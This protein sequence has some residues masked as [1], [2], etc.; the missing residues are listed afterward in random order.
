M[1]S[2]RHLLPTHRH[3]VDYIEFALEAEVH[4]SN[5]VLRA[6]EEKYRSAGTPYSFWA[7]TEGA[8]LADF[9]KRTFYRT[10]YVDTPDNSLCT[11]FPRQPTDRVCCGAS[12]PDAGKALIL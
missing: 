10:D 6:G 9:R 2:A 8:T 4:H 12:K 5:K 3:D 7:G 11:G 1:T